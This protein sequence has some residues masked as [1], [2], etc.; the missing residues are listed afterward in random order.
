VEQRKRKRDS[1]DDSDDD[2]SGSIYSIFSDDLLTVRYDNGNP[3]V[4]Q[5]IRKLFTQRI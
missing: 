1:D 4:G 2:S 3:I 5:I